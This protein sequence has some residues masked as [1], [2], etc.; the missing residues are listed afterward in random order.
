MK[1]IILACDYCVVVIVFSY[2][3][4]HESSAISISFVRFNVKSLES[5]KS[6]VSCDIYCFL[7]SFRNA[8]YCVLS[9]STSSLVNVA[10]S[11]RNVVFVIVVV[12]YIPLAKSI[13]SHLS[14]ITTIN[15]INTHTEVDQSLVF[16]TMKI[17]SFS[18][19]LYLFVFR[20]RR[21]SRSNL[22]HTYTCNATYFKR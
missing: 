14:M 18:F 16:T 3:L 15:S 4:L 20:W 2:S 17:N 22:Q 8:C 1:T 21:A 9:S 12:L 6:I 13:A 7:F 19:Y 10:P 5:I 11:K